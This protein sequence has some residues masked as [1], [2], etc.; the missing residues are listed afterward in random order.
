MR[1][2]KGLVDTAIFL[3]PTLATA[4][5]LY[6]IS[7]GRAQ[8]ITPDVSVPFLL[9]V[10][11]QTLGITVVKCGVDSWILSRASSW[12]GRTLILMP[13]VM[14]RYVPLAGAVG[15]LLALRLPLVESI[16]AAL[17]AL[18][19]AIALVL[20][21]EMAAQGR[22]RG[23]GAANWLKYPL[24]F[25]AMVGL[26]SLVHVSLELLLSAFLVTSALRL[27]ALLLM[28][29]AGVTEGNERPHTV[30]LAA[31]QVLN[32][33]LFKNDQLAVGILNRGI[34]STDALFVYLAR[35]P[36]LVSAVVTSVGPLLYP[37]LYPSKG[38][39]DF[40]ARMTPTFFATATIV[41]IAAAVYGLTAGGTLSGRLW[42][43]LPAVTC[44]GLLVMPVNFRTYS[45]LREEHDR[46]LLFGLAGSNA[47]GTAIVAVAAVCFPRLP[48]DILW[49]TPLQQVFFLWATRAANPP[50]NKT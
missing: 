50:A 19:D 49:L 45:L 1:G 36:E 22:I 35:F 38:A 5:G 32:Y 3:G 26:A 41:V 34:Q 29:P 25:L 40:G 12:R 20:S 4:G 14:R 30:R 16:V 24:F 37:R 31:Q 44:H 17:T 11:W 48:P 13:L 21:N 6:W 43:L 47:I 18:I 9:F 33:G 39:S 23:S 28:R 27:I 7:T 15:L 10:P 8:G 42:E 2:R 46:K